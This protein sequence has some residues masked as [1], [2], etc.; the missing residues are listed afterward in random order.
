MVTLHQAGDSNGRIERRKE[1]RKEGRKERRK[2]GRKERRKEL[3]STLLDY[4]EFGDSNT[5]CNR[6]L[7]QEISRRYMYIT[8]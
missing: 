4:L 5:H 1:R 2:E 6:D 8:V 7:A 3:Q